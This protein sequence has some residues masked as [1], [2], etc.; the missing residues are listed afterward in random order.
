M[1]FL[2]QDSAENAESRKV[3]EAGAAVEGFEVLGWREVPID[4]SVVGKI[5]SATQPQVAQVVL[6]CSSGRQGAELERGLYRA[7]KAMEKGHSN[8]EFYVCS[9]SGK[10]SALLGS[11]SWPASWVCVDV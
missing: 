4:A 5:A 6:K 1:V 2:P 9:I 7:R 8:D 11:A 3:V 10:V